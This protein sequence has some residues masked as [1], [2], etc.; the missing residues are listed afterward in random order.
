MDYTEKTIKTDRV[1][2]GKVINF[3]VDTVELP[4]GKT[5]IREL[6]EHPGGVGIVVLDNDNNIIMVEQF[7]KPY[8]KTILEIPAG[9][10]DKGENTETCGRRELEEETGLLADEFICLGECYPS[11]GYTDEVITLYL[12]KG[13]KK[14]SQH[15]DDD[16]FLDLVKIPFAKAVEMIMNNEICDAKTIV[17]ILKAKEVLLK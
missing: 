1:Y 5:A 6:V 10:R 3:K 15:L 2:E 4:N 16:E 7:R 14:S 11:V 13:L 9:K 8:D 17:G 12:A